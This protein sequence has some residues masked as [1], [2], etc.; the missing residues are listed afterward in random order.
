MISV[1][2][3]HVVHICAFFACVMHYPCVWYWYAYSSCMLCVF[4]TYATRIL[5]ICYAS[6]L[7]MICIFF[8]YVTATILRK[9]SRRGVVAPFPPIFRQNV[10]T[11]HFWNVNSNP[12]P[13]SRLTLEVCV[14]SIGFL[15]RH[16]EIREKTLGWGCRK[17]TGCGLPALLTT[18]RQDGVSCSYYQTLCTQ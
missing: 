13:V 18:W 3:A 5:R 6:S 14:N 10:L 9:C 8:A 11:M 7:R 17:W 2:F 4:F 12:V 15:C 1:F 16:C